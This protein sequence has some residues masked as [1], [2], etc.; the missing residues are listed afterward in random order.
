M[1]RVGEDLLSSAQ[2]LKL[3]LKPNDTQDW[4][5]LPCSSYSGAVTVLNTRRGKLKVD[6]LHSQLF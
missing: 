1:K 6:V 2:L 5:C 4:Y 3:I